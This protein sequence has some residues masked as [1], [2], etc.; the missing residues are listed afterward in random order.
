MIAAIDV[1]YSN[2]TA[3]VGCVRF[4]AWNSHSSAHE[5]TLVTQASEDYV[6]GQ[7]YL[8]ELPCILAI[9]DA[10]ERNCSTIIID[11][12]VWLG[13]DRP[14]MGYHLYE[15]LGREIPVVGVAKNEFADNKV[16][17]PITR[18]TSKQP[19]YITAAGIDTGLA[20]QA[21][22][23]MHG[24]HRIPTLLKLADTL[25]RCAAKRISTQTAQQS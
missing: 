23:D 10:I 5:D 11:G 15:T 17:Q 8:R 13:A 6:P 25:C 4:E 14:G 3:V 20:A 7:F 19:L 21:V 9:L 2:T 16:A 12:Y 18:A 24:P 22:R 1:Q